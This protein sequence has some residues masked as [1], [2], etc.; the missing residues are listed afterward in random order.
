MKNIYEEILCAG[1]GGQGIMFLGKLLAQAGL[2]AGKHVSWMPSYGAE[3]RGGTAYSMV[4]VA[5]HEIATPVVTHPEILIVMN[6]PSLLKYEERLKPGGV[7]V[8]NS[9]LIDVRPSRKD[10]KVISIPMTE[11][12]VKIGDGRTAN[13]VALGACIKGSGILTLAAVMKA[14]EGMLAGKKE[15]LKANKAA[16]EKGYRIVK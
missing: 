16:I 9:S 3:V 15:L 5:G 8:M 13:M 6:K 10:I 2:E 11:I 14:L 1:F 12:A 4:R 7:L